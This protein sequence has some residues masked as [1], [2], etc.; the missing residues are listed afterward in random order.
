MIFKPYI[1]LSIYIYI[2]LLENSSIA[3]IKMIISANHHKTKSS[4]DTKKKKIEV[5]IRRQENNNNDNDNDDDE[6]LE[7]DMLMIGKR[8]LRLII[9]YFTTH[10]FPDGSYFTWDVGS[11]LLKL[12]ILN[13]ISPETINVFIITFMKHIL[14]EQIDNDLSKVIDNKT[15]NSLLKIYYVYFVLLLLNSLVNII[16]MLNI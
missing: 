1:E 12:K 4:K 3:E 2:L 6:L 16:K 5:Q 8:E 7:N 10:G 14:S 9:K 15:I 11:V 13:K